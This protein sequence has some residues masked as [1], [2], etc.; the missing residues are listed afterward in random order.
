MITLNRMPNRIATATLPKTDHRTRSARCPIVLIQT[1]YLLLEDSELRVVETVR[2]QYPNL[3]I[4]ASTNSFAATEMVAV[5]AVALK[6]Q[7]YL[8]ENLRFE[9]HE[10]KPRPG[11]IRRMIRFYDDLVAD[12]EDKDRTAKRPAFSSRAAPKIGLHC[13]S[14]VVDDKVAWVGSH[15]FDPRSGRWNT[16]SALAV[17]DER[18]ARA[19][20][21]SMLGYM[22]PQNSWLVARRRHLPI[23]GAGTKWIENVSRALPVLDIWPT[24]YTTCYQLRPGQEPVPPDDPHF[25]EHYKAVGHFPQEGFSWRR[26]KAR[27]YLA[28]GG[29]AEGLL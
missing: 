8:A 9:I 11:D 6:Q 7:K 12:G 28:F 13:K 23:L 25:H 14:F 16:E 27:L 17:W 29:L 10:L 18:V 26:V 20:K 4:Q 3:R 2:R 15:N 19:L 1:P 24:F 21:E 22:A 5:Y